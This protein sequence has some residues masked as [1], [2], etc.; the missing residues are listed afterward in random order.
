M[1]SATIKTVEQL[2][3]MRQERDINKTTLS[4]CAGANQSG[5]GNALRN[6]SCSKELKENV[7]A[8]FKYYDRRGIVPEPN[9]LQLKELPGP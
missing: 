1:S 9:E 8:V 7:V 4:T 6:G 3:K 2:E 5:W